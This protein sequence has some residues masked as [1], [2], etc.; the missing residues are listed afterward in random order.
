MKRTELDELIEAG[1]SALGMRD[2]LKA[3]ALFE[4]AAEIEATPT[5]RSSLAYC[6]ARERGQI[7]SG[8]QLCE[9]L[10]ANEPENLFHQLNL[11]RILLLSGDRRAA[12]RAFRAG[13]LL[14]P[15]PQIIAE[16]NRLGVRKPLVFPFLHRDNLLNKYLGLLRNHLAGR[17]LDRRKNHAENS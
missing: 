1:T 13:I 17:K 8:R 10:V 3:L 4:R 7:K 9:E 15:H 12:V 11:G 5:V 6:M 2:S 14:D 16:L